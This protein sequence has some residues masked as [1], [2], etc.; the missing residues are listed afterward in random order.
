MNALDIYLLCTVALAC[1]LWFLTF[2]T[3]FFRAKTK[4]FVNAEDAKAFEGKLDAQEVEPVLR[5]QAAH[6][7]ALESIPLFL[8]LGFLYVQTS[9]PS[10]TG[11]MAYLISFTVLRWLH[12]IVYLKGL[13]PWRTIFFGLSVLVMVGLAVQLAIAA[14]S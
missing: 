6:R 14:L 1:N 10:T 13:Q 11:A 4:T 2:A 5:V 12:S 9:S 8:I 7:N 3:G